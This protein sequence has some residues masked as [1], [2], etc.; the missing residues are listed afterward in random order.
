LSDDLRLS[1]D[2]E[3]LSSWESL[4]Q[5]LKKRMQQL[6]RDKILLEVDRRV[7]FRETSRLLNLLRR[8]TP[9]TNIS[10]GTVPQK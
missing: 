8:R 3:V 9:I 2:G 6:H 4:P 10:I 7:P 1:I 5:A